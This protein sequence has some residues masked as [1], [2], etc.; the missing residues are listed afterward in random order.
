M[1]ERQMKILEKLNSEN[2]NTYSSLSDTF[3]VTTRTIRNDIEDIN[4]FLKRYNI[5]IYKKGNFLNFKYDNIND[6]K[7]FINYLRGRKNFDF[8]ISKNRIVFMGLTLLLSEKYIKLDY[9]LEKFYISKSTLNNDFKEVKSIFSKYNLKINV[10]P[11][12]GIK[13]FSEEENIRKVIVYFIQMLEKDIYAFESINYL[14]NFSKYI[15]I[16]Y[17]I[18]KS[19]IIKYN[20]NISDLSMNNLALHILVSIIRIRNKKFIYINVFE[21]IE[22]VNQI[23]KNKHIEIGEDIILEIEKEFS[24]EF[25]IIEFINFCKHLTAINMLQDFYLDYDIDFDGLIKDILYKLSDSTG[26]NLMCDKELEYSLLMHLKPSIYRIK[27]NIYLKNPMLKDIKLNYTYFY[28]LGILT[29][30]IVKEKIDIIL[31][32]DEIGYIALHIGTSI[33][34]IN[35]NVNNTKLKCLIVCA[36]GFGTSKL[37][38]LKI[39]HFFE[40]DI[41]IFDVTQLYSLRKYDYNS[42]DFIIS[43]IDIDKEIKKDVIVIQNILDDT[44]YNK[45]YNYIN[46]KT[47]NLSYLDRSNFFAFQ[48]FNS[49]EELLKFVCNDLYE[50]KFA[51]RGLYDS[52]IKR[53]ELSSSSIGNLVAI[54]HPIEKM[55]EKTFWTVISLRKEIEW[56]KNKVKFVIMLNIINEEKKYLDNMY[57]NMMKLIS[58]KQLIQELTEI[59][60][61]NELYNRIIKIFE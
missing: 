37:M 6:Y 7:N 32:E 49:K 5:C 47:I 45:I 27:N 16:I 42:Y 4:I 55:S 28:D 35:K 31:N 13:V 30:K 59:K 24:I 23:K 50:R 3:E 10:K 8:T 9:F 44:E 41:E 15:K 39:E 61:S 54:P 20:I 33:E 2:S 38:K 22:N 12:H 18:I 57:K 26:I 52:I 58:D 36:T 29:A 51:K 17:N 1:N 40:N 43:N 48:D 14:D 34:K 60:D 53:E 11:G 19:K 46:I 21:Q 25:P 56:G